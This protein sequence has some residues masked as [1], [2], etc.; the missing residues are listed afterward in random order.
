MNKDKQQLGKVLQF[1]NSKSRF[2]RLYLRQVKTRR[3]VLFISTMAVILVN[4]LLLSAA[5]ITMFSVV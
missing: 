3:K 4:I 5:L 2:L 1:P